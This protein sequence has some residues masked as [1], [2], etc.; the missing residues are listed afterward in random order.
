[1]PINFQRTAVLFVA[2][3]GHN[4]FLPCIHCKPRVFNHTFLRPRLGCKLNFGTLQFYI[5]PLQG[6]V[7]FSCMCPTTLSFQRIFSKFILNIHWTMLQTPIHF[8]PRLVTFVVTVRS[9]LFFTVCTL[10]I[11]VFNSC[12]SNSYQILIGLRSRLQSI[13]VT[14][15]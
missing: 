8:C 7:R 15:K 1:M 3:R 14:H 2:T 5:W 12:S 13:F 6:Q 10:Q 9:N 4:L 11:R